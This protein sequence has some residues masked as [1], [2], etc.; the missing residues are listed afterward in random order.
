MFNA[1]NEVAVES[2]LKKKIT[3]TDIYDV[4]YRTFDSIAL[5]KE[6]DIESLNELD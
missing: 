1:A 2:F 6:L 3:F 4:I 5:S